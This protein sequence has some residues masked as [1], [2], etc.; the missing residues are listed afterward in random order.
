MTRALAALP[1]EEQDAALRE[2]WAGLLR[3]LRPYFEAVNAVLASDAFRA[4]AAQVATAHR[5][6]ARRVHTAYRRR[7]R[8][9]WYR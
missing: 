7:T 9:R 1:P 2:L 5:A 3:A 6:H 4:F 8:G